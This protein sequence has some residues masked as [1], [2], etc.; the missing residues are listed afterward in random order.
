MRAARSESGQ[1]TVD[2]IALIAVVALLIVAATGSIGSGAPSI[3]NGVLGGVQRALCVVTGRTCPSLRQQPCVTSSDR[4]AIH[5]VVSVLVYRVDRERIVLREN[6]SDGTVRL[7][8]ARRSSGGVEV[9]IGGRMQVRLPGRAFGAGREAR[10]GVQGVFGYGEVF[11]AHNGPE[12]DAIM[13][14]LLRPRLPLVDG[15]PGA[16]EIF[17]EGGVRGLA[18]LG[19]GSGL[20]GA[21]LD[22]K[23]DGILG[24]RRDQRSGEV[25]LS[26]NAGASGWGLLNALL[27]GESSSS[28]RTVGLELQLDR[29]GRP[30]GLTLRA[31]GSLA[32]GESLALSLPGRQGFTPTVAS[33]GGTEGRRWELEARVDLDD[34]GV[35]AAWATFRRDRT[36]P[37][38]VRELAVQLR[39][40][41][42]LDVR[43]YASDG[44]SAGIAAGVALALKIGAEA[45][46]TDDSARLLSAQSRP[47]GGLWEQRI[48]CMVT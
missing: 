15:L 45:E 41:A 36:D 31:T 42:H 35:A 18:R 26:L 32:A 8:L 46:I 11:V 17:A 48:D 2:Y 27:A 1:A 44:R 5:T 38:A 19:L 33:G 24:V 39:D 13:R 7:T 12:A 4:K 23:A 20:A 9:G 30:I 6:M 16:R 29:H 40:R 21:S 22:G 47:P 28:E 3:V 25:T 10:V 14:R 37:A 34:P 43:S